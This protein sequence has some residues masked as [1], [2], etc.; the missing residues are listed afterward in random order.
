[1]SFHFLSIYYCTIDG[2]YYDISYMYILYAD[3][4]QFPTLYLV[5]PSMFP[6]FYF[7]A[8]ILPSCIISLVFFFLII[9]TLMHTY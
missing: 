9:D 5:L 6:L 3:H 2:F 7:Q 8:L 4:L 1:M